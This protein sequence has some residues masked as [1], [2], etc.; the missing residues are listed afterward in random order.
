MR[1]HRRL[2]GGK[3]GRAALERQAIHVLPVDRPAAALDAQIVRAFAGDTE[4]FHL[5]G[6]RQDAISILQQHERFADAITRDLAMAR[7]ADGGEKLWRALARFERPKLIL[8]AQNAKHCVVD[9]GY[10]N[11]ALGHERL[12]V[13]DK[14]T[15]GVCL[16]GIGR[17]PAEHAESSPCRCPH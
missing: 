16:G 1:G 3:D 8:D 17:K 2:H 14:V 6:K 7:T 11:P 10:W 4:A 12:E 15:I 13:R 5:P 9:A